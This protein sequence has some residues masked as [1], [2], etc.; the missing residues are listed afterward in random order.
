[1]HDEHAER[2]ADRDHGHAILRLIRLAVDTPDS[3][4]GGVLTSLHVSTMAM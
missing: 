3:A 2:F 4:I 1:V